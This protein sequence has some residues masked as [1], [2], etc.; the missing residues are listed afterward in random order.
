MQKFSAFEKKNI[1]V[2]TAI[3]A[4]AFFIILWNIFANPRISHSATTLYYNNAMA[5]GDWGNLSN[6][7]QDAGFTTPADAL[8]TSSDDVHIY[9]PIDTDTSSSASANIATFYGADYL[10]VGVGV[11][12]AIF[13]DSSYLNTGGY[14][15]GS[16]TFNSTSFMVGGTVSGTAYFYGSSSFQGGDFYGDIKFYD[17]ASV[18]IGVSLYGDPIFRGSSFNGG[19][20]YPST[21]AYFLDTSGNA[22]LIEGDACFVPTASNQGTVTG[23]ETVCTGPQI[24]TL[25]PVD[26]ST[27]F[28]AS[29]DLI[30]N[31]D[32]GASVGTG[33][34]NIYKEDG[35][36]DVLVEEIDVTSGQVTGDGTSEI[37][38]NPTS[39]LEPAES[40]Y[41][42]IDSGTFTNFLDLS[43]DGIADATTWNFSTDA[44][45]PT[46]S[47]LSP[48]DDATSTVISNNLVIEFSEEVNSG[49][50]NVTIYN[51]S[52]DSIFEEID[53][54]HEQVTGEG[55][56]TI[57]INPTSN[58]T[59]GLSYYVQIDDTAF[60]DLSGNKFAGIADA[61]TWNFTADGTA[62]TISTLSPSDGGTSASLESNLVITF[63]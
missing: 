51:A 17:N 41:V 47:T 30:I 55:T 1:I 5:D 27:G 40:Y 12:S 54:I 22:S 57:T 50:G 33:S 49:S 59:G 16:A 4:L 36:D 46:I 37:T 32:V 62:P 13:E 21:R 44:T 9:G 20:I 42:L 26:D 10:S 61:T 28:V 63:S 6:W 2:K 52:D 7:W 60:A 31:F 14:I 19:T 29:E 8:P 23:E 34:I 58:F 48:A 3:F 56:D 53:V 25:S 15:S 18:S 11:G 35:S 45:A 24:T 38:I 39:N 43:F